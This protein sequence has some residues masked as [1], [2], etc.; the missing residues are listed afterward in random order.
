M[1]WKG[2]WDDLIARISR[3]KSEPEMVPHNFVTSLGL[4]RKLAPSA[5]PEVF[6]LICTLVALV[7]P[8]A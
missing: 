1:S 5:Y 7:L 4:V 6:N 8:R 2:I 3:K